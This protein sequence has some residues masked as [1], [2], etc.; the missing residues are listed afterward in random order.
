[1]DL[2]TLITS[3]VFV[4]H[5]LFGP[6]NPPMLEQLLI[7]TPGIEVQPKVDA[8][9]INGA[10]LSYNWTHAD[11]AEGVNAR[12]RLP[13]GVDTVIVT[14]AIPLDNHL[15]WSG[16][17]DAIAQF[18]EVARTGNP[19]VTFY[20][21][22]TWHSLNSGTGT[23][24]PFDDGM[25]TPWRE[26]LESDLPKWEAAVTQ[27]H[28][29]TGGDIQLLKAGQAMARL[30]DAITAGTVP[31][32]NSINDMFVDDIHPNPLGFYFIS[33]FQYATLT[34][35]SPVGL[36][37]ALKNRWGEAYPAPSA[38]LAA[39]LQ[40]IAERAARN[41][42][43]R[44]VL[45]SA[46][47]SLPDDPP[48]FGLNAFL[49]EEV[50]AAAPVADYRQPMAMNLS[51]IADWSPQAPFLDHF[52]TTRPWI[53]HIAGQWG[54][55]EEADLSAAG[56]LDPNGWPTS[57]PPELGSIGT[58]FL[59]DLPEDAR[60]LAGRYRLQYSGD[61]IL[62][63][64]GRAKNVRYGNGE[65]WFDFTPGPGFVDIRI[66]RTDRRGT[67]DYIRDISVV[68]QEH[69]DLYAN[70][71]TFN[72]RWLKLLDGF[73]TLRFMDWMD[74]NDSSQVGWEDR[75]LATDYTWARA[76]VPAEILMELS[77]RLKADPWVSMPHMSDDSYMR[78]FARL[79]HQLLDPDLT[80]YVEFS[81]EVWN[82]QFTQAQWAEQQAQ[83]HWSGEN[84]WM[85]FNGGRAAEMAEI[86]SEIFA[87][88]MTR[89]VRVIS[90][91]TGWLGLER[92]VLKAPLWKAERA[93]RRE[94]HHYFDAYAIT[95]YF[96][97]VLGRTEYADVVR[98][99]IA[100]SRQHAQEIGRAK[101]LNGKA[102]FDFLQKHQFDVA[103]AQA[104]IEL[105]DGLI[106]GDEADTLADFLD[107]ILPYHVEVAAQYDLDLIMYEGGSHV[108][109]VGSNV[110]D[111]NLTAF[112][113]HF[114][115]TAEM[116]TLYQELL[117]GWK[118][119][120]GQLFAAYADVYTPSKWGSWGALRSLTD[121]NP[122]WT[123][124]EA[125][126]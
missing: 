25:G 62:E 40:E 113:T 41:D 68:K 76:G 66:Q 98:A 118:A 121:Q 49:P 79:T 57:I 15:K 80:A 82:W 24:I 11:Q 71:Q 125:A 93:D 104:Q 96:G 48:H 89:L 55:I 61:G 119:A 94:P 116:G 44:T 126:K 18:Y 12:E 91:Q 100:D 111:E 27:A 4:G 47:R 107:R 9:I 117:R 77:N 109:G 92:D 99:W 97:G 65:I 103:S 87:D 20:V 64:T 110:E 28:E 123:A 32:V 58:V 3:V 70:G 120:G 67:G 52:K 81:N 17:A 43:R 63:V 45:P 115:Y 124:I 122:R 1:M 108:V 72:P 29:L 74:I 22:E 86:W 39:R 69:I 26:R 75:P 59:T 51:P 34:G 95:G 54:G 53:G 102:L 112:F 38:E 42:T 56:Y 105:R 23:P 6:D 50:P 90:T 46:V 114:N 35:H 106:S 84:L 7:E 36:P 19:D 14:E 85:Q 16:T 21:Q 73:T 60:S 37:A 78:N 33:L 83:N 88:D 2:N 8:Q 10:P 5:S 31:G 30:D 101:G 13:Q